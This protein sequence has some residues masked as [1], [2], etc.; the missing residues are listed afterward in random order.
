VYSELISKLEVLK[1]AMD[2]GFLVRVVGS[3]L[4]EILNLTSDLL[5]LAGQSVRVN[6]QEVL[7][8]GLKFETE[9]K[10]SASEYSKLS[11]IDQGAYWRNP[12]DGS[13]YQSSSDPL[14]NPLQ[15]EI[16]FEGKPLSRKD[17]LK[18]ANG[19]EAIGQFLDF[20]ALGRI[21][22]QFLA[23]VLGKGGTKS[24]SRGK[25][26]RPR[27]QYYYHSRKSSKGGPKRKNVHK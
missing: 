25:D 10:I 19:L 24:F 21:D 20:L 13:Y 16:P 17:S 8:Y 9:T 5:T 18:I 11:V 3:P 7:N 1:T 23:Q 26:R 2:S 4:S 12:I 6:R 22:H 15:I 27:K 14:G